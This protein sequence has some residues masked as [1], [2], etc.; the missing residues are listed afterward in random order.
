MT[1]HSNLASV[2]GRS[3]QPSDPALIDLSGPEPVS[4][5][6]GALS[7]EASGVAANLRARGHRPGARIGM[8]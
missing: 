2:L 8:L 4:Y 3:S 6:Y 7:A 5:T 1:G